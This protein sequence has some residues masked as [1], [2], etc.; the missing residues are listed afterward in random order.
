MVETFRDAPTGKKSREAISDE[1]ENLTGHMKE[2]QF[3]KYGVPDLI[4][5]AYALGFID[6]IS[7]DIRI[8]KGSEFMLTYRGMKFLNAEPA[9][10]QRMLLQSFLQL[11]RPFQRLVNHLWT[12]GDEN[13]V[14]YDDFQYLKEVL[15]PGRWNALTIRSFITRNATETVMGSVIECMSGG[16]GGGSRALYL[17]T[18]SKN[19]IR[20]EWV[21]LSK[22]E[23]ARSLF[24]RDRLGLV[25][26][27]EIESILHESLLMPKTEMES[28]LLSLSQ[29]GVFRMN[30]HMRRPISI[31]MT[32]RVAEDLYNELSRM[33]E[34]P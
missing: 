23:I 29:A 8:G 22:Y 17:P 16:E 25:K 9:V 27:H 20:S 33:F 21:T 24:L 5:M 6:K 2:R 10:E 28:L 3:K 34:V 15:S 30:L 12:T 19:R 31:T 14:A 18:S 11:C 7:E 32:K 1:V 26:I 13:P 4:K